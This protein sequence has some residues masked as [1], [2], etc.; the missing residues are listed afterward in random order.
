MLCHSGVR[1]G[2]QLTR[3]AGQRRPFRTMLIVTSF[4]REAVA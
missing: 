2:D 3:C 1:D 4:Q